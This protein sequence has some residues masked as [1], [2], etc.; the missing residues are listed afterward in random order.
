MNKNKI[1]C[2]HCQK[3]ITSNNIE[4][5]LVSCSIPKPDKIYKFNPRNS[6]K[7][8]R[9]QFMKASA[10]GREIPKLSDETKFKIL[11]SK[12]RNGTF[13]HTEESRQKISAAMKRAVENNPDAYTSSNRGRVK[14]I[15]Y[16]DIKFHGQWEVDF[17][18]W[19]KEEGL[20]PTKAM[21][22]FKYNWNGVRTYFPDFY[23]E[24]MDLYVE[25]KGYETERDSAKWS[26]FPKDL[27]VIKHSEIK[28]IRTNQF[29]ASML[30]L[31]IKKK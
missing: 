1:A 5:H 6:G 15:I 13:G 27:C 16:D 17:Y 29:K 31:T 9:N 30:E 2:Q 4:R 21:Q 24:S 12:K 14:Q 26:Q 7:K 25:V 18:K 3:E 28:K 19:A 10:E 8:G 11:A 22:G 20:N 23:I